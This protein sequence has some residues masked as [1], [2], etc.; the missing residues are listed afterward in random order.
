[1]RV[2]PDEYLRLPLRAHELLRGVRLYDVSIVDLPGG[3][4]G[5]TLADLRAINASARPSGIAKVLFGLRVLL[6]RVF[7]WD[8]TKILPEQSLLPRLTEADRNASQIP[9]GTSD[10]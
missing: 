7:R 5:R 8:R 6:G 1:M 4:E 2:R 9:P 3:G 10:G